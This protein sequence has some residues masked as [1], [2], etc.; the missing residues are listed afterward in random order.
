MTMK[1]RMLRLT[2]LLSAVGAT[3]LA[4]GASVRGF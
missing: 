3:L 2:Y 1:I 4:G